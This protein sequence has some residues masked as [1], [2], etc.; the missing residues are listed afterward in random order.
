M[1]R[2]VTL[3]EES[4]RCTLV[5]KLTINTEDVEAVVDSE[6]QVSV[7]SKGF[8]DSLGDKPP[9][10]EKIRL[11]GASASGVMIASRIDD[12]CVGLCGVQNKQSMYV[13]DINDKCILGLDY[14]KTNKAVIDLDKGVLL[15]GDMRIITGKYKYA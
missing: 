9:I 8:Y 3:R 1:I 13:A 12:V 10:T 5:V 7:L 2:E 14:L 6:A 4:D 15:L 11:I